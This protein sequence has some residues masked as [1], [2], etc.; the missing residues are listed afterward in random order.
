M[1]KRLLFDVLPTLEPDAENKGLHIRGT[2][3]H[4]DDIY[5]RELKSPTLTFRREKAI[6]D[7]GTSFWER[8]F[9]I[10]KLLEMQR[11]NPAVFA[12]QYQNDVG[13]MREMAAIKQEWI[14]SYDF[15]TLQRHGLYYQIAID[16]GGITEQEDTSAMGISLVGAQSTPGSTFGNI[17][18]LESR[19]LHVDTWTGAKILSFTTKTIANAWA[20]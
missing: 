14:K 11:R 4:P 12:A 20:S 10:A 3:Y 6:L 8:M 17:Y 1:W 18:V 15:S 7:N 19:N 9:P 2:R 16:P 5:G 13:A